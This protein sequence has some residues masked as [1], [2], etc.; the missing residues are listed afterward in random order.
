MLEQGVPSTP[1][2]APCLWSCP[3]LPFRTGSW[4]KKHPL[5]QSRWVPGASNPQ[6]PLPGPNF[7]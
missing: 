3:A 2:L 7:G 5:A 1:E 6:H 4:E